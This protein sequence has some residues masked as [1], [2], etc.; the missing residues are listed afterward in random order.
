SGRPR[1]EARGR[2]P[3]ALD[4]GE[5]ARKDLALD[6]GGQLQLPLD[7]LLL[8]GRAVQPGRLDRRRGLVGEEGQ[9]PRVGGREIED[10]AVAGFLVGDGEDAQP[11]SADRDR[12]REALD[13]G[14][15]PNSGSR[16]R[17]GRVV[18]D[19]IAFGKLP[20]R[21]E[22]RRQE[23][24]AEASLEEQAPVLV[25]EGERPLPRVGQ[26][27]RAEQHFVRERRDLELAAERQAEV[28]ERLELDQARTDLE[29][30][31]LDLAA[32]AVRAEKPAE[33]DSQERRDLGRLSRGDAFEGEL[34]VDLSLGGQ[35]H[36]EQPLARRLLEIL[37]EK[38]LAPVAGH[39]A[40]DPAFALAQVDRRAPGAAPAQ[41]RPGQPGEEGFGARERLLQRLPEAGEPG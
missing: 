19:R 41:R 27:D 13:A 11:A 5:R 1:R 9:Q 10:A 38:S 15:Q 25:E 34:A 30:R 2:E 18:E 20:R 21:E 22:I 29:V 8:D 7:A 3:D 17:G 32:V 36:E 23:L 12:H 28:V 24:L 40:A 31:L 33:T 4:L 35:R 14:S 37:V 6:G 16:D 26:R 39:G